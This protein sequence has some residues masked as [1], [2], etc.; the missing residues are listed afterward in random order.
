[1]HTTMEWRKGDG[2]EESEEG[3][4]ITAFFPLPG[5]AITGKKEKGA[6]N[7]KDYLPTTKMGNA[8]D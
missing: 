1:M 8:A 4:G 7:G 6:I 3:R 2:G 5:I